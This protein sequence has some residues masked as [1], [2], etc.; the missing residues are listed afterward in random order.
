M[1][2]KYIPPLI[3]LLAGILMCVFLIRLGSYDRLA[4]SQVFLFYG[5]LY[6]ADAGLITHTVINRR[7]NLSVTNFG[8]KLMA[9]V[10][11]FLALVTF[12]IGDIFFSH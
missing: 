10:L 3:W 12:M 11:I 1:R 9:E 7:E 8:F 6:V 4:L 2:K 5:A